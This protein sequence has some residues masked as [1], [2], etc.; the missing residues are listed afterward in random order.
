MEFY[1]L[2]N[3]IKEG[4]YTI[5]ELHHK[6]INTKTMIWRVGFTNWLPAHQVPE[7]SDILSSLP[8]DPLPPP[9]KTW[10][11]ESILVTCFC[12]LPFGIVGIINAT[13]VETLY[14]NGN[15]KLA[16]EQSNQAKKWTLWGFFIM[17]AFWIIYLFIIGIALIID[18]M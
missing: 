6:N 3:N 7:L 11:I 2:I 8:P 9:P 13:K 15:Y 14:N 4:P 16:L 10:L 12:C 1:I 5:E 17:L 18:S